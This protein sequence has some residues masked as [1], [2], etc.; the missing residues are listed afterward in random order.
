MS[1][2][3]ALAVAA[4]VLAAEE[5]DT[6]RIKTALVDP[7]VDM[8]VEA[9]MAQQQFKDETN[10]NTIVRRFGVTYEMPA[11]AKNDPGAYGDFTGVEDFRSAL[12]RVREA[13]DNFAA[14]PAALRKK[15]DNDPARFIE[16]V[17]SSDNVE[18]AVELGIL[19]ESALPKLDATAPV[20]AAEGAA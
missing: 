5:Y 19:S 6:P 20:T 14:L 11:P 9:D 4:G 1:Q 16:Y 3:I 18:E 13:Q 15:F 12:D 17:H 10:I 2:V 8:S 7:V